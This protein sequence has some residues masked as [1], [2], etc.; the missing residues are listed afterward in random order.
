MHVE[1]KLLMVQFSSYGKSNLVSCQV[2][3]MQNDVE[4]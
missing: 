2:L 1:K 4:K 3:A